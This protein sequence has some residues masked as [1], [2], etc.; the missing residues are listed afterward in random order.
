[1]EMPE[2]IQFFQ[3]I[4]NSKFPSTTPLT[5]FPVLFMYLLLLSGNR[6]SRVLVSAAISGCEVISRKVEST[7][8]E[9]AVG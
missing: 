1:M 4:P 6:S 2:I 9:P 7:S 3:N 5:L 8:E